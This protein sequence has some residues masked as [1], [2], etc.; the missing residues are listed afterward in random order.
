MNNNNKLLGI[1]CEFS[2][3][4]DLLD[5][6]ILLG[7]LQRYGFRGVKIKWFRSYL[8]NRSQQVQLGNTSSTNIYQIHPGTP[9]GSILGLFCF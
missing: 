1:F 7:K 9:Q 5:Q 4:F 3:A 8:T 2:K 6:E